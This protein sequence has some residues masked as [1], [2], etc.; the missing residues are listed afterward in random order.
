MADIFKMFRQWSK[1]DELKQSFVFEAEQVSRFLDDAPND[2]AN[3]PAKVGV[4]LGVNGLL[5][6]AENHVI[7][8]N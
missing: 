1:L 7:K 8:H 4:I 2:Y 3:L 6:P 5:R